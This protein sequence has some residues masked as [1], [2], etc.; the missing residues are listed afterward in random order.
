MCPRISILMIFSLDEEPGKPKYS[1]GLL[2]QA[3][4]T[5]KENVLWLPKKD[6]SD[7]SRPFI[8]APRGE[9]QYCSM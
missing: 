4:W 9:G 2:K 1:P 8:W 6:F 7:S 3:T 5:Q